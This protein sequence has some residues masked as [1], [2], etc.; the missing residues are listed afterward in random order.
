MTCCTPYMSKKKKGFVIT[1]LHQIR[2][3]M[4]RILM[5]LIN[6]KKKKRK[7][8]TPLTIAHL[9]RTHLPQSLAFLDSPP[10]SMNPS[11]FNDAS[12]T[13][14][15]IPLT[16][17]SRLWLYPPDSWPSQRR[18]SAVLA[19]DSVTVHVH[20]LRTRTP[21]VRRTQVEVTFQPEVLFP[22]AKC[23]PS[24]KDTQKLHPHKRTLIAHARRAGIVKASLTSTGRLSL[25]SPIRNQLT[26]RGLPWPLIFPQ[27][28]ITLRPKI[29]FFF[30]LSSPSSIF[31]SQ[32]TP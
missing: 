24:T 10:D 32:K 20:V 26:T 30:F 27:L 22:P 23:R 8:S 2:P 16:G 3:V 31:P 29:I 25:N 6:K 28:N 19:S 12:R 14:A 7:I 13:T 11:I 17:G 4:I 21:H 18:L 9:L 15:S 1:T 5:L